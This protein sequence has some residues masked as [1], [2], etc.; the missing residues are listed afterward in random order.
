MKRAKDRGETVFFFFFFYFSLLT[1]IRLI[2]GMHIFEINGCRK[3]PGDDR[4]LDIATR[5]PTAT[6]VCGTG[7]VLRHH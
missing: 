1:V 4:G 5:D 2:V 7:I 3:K 6:L